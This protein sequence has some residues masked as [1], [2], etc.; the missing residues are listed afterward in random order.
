[1]SLFVDQSFFLSL[2]VL[3]LP[4]LILGYLE[5]PI[6][7]YG[8][9]VSLIYVY[10]AMGKNPGAL[11]FLALFLA[12]SY[13]LDR[14]YLVARQRWGRKTWLYRIFLFASILPLALYKFSLAANWQIHLFG[15]LGLSYMTFKST[16]IIIQTYDGSI[17]QV[18]LWD[19]LYMDLFFPVL[20]SGPI[21]RS[22]RF[23]GD[24]HRV[25]PREDYMDLA[26]RGL[27]KILLG[28]VYKFALGASFYHLYTNFGMKADLK[29][30]LVYFYGYGFYLF[31]D[32]AGYS[33]MA[34]GASY[35]FGIETPENFRAPFRSLDIIEFWD[36]WHISLSHWFRDFIF[37][38]ISMGL[39]KT[40]RFKKRLTVA[41]IAFFINMGIMG[42]WH[43]TDLQYLI[44]GLYHGLLLTLT[45]IF[46]KKS[47]FYKKHRKE[48]WF[49][50]VSWGIT[51]H[52][53]FFG[54]FIFSGRFLELTGLK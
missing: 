15:F 54:F 1:M 35:L 3:A 18:S 37:S 17:D 48:K 10:L 39:M 25:L 41:G 28:A 30:T 46:H 13:A 12:V 21:D 44:Y 42:I 49:Q 4:A 22:Q 20:T 50:L 6:A 47:S 29:H 9:L 45:E 40:K 31:F 36:R 23:I 2:I 34:V 8:S 19:F 38:R 11:A 26:G 32:F 51:F 53:V 24:M 27:Q 33:L 14:G 52:L 43:G 7:P 5:K 16:Q